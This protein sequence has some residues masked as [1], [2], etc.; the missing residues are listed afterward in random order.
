MFPALSFAVKVY[1]VPLVSF[2]IDVSL[3]LNILLSI[4]LKASVDSVT[5]TVTSY[6]N[7]LFKPCFPLNTILPITGFVLSNLYFSQIDSVSPDLFVP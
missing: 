5:L 2:V 7:Q 1:V 4:P 3:G 6:T